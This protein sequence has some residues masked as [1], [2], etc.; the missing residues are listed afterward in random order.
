MTRPLLALFL[1]I[2]Y[3]SQVFAESRLIFDSEF[4]KVSQILLKYQVKDDYIKM[5]DI[6]LTNTNFG[7]R[8]EDPK[9]LTAYWPSEVFVSGKFELVLN[10]GDILH[11]ASITP[12]AVQT[13]I[14]NSG[15]EYKNSYPNHRI[16]ISMQNDWMEKVK[17]AGGLFFCLKNAKP[18]GG[19]EICSS[20]FKFIKNQIGLSSRNT[21]T[22]VLINGSKIAANFGEFALDPSGDSVVQWFA[23]LATGLSWSIQEKPPEIKIVE[24]VKVDENLYRL[25]G[26]GRRPL[27][28]FND[29]F[30]YMNHSFL[31]EY[32][33]DPFTHERED[34]WSVVISAIKPIDLSF[35]NPQGGIYTAR[36]NIAEAP[37]LLENPI[38]TNKINPQLTYSSATRYQLQLSPDSKPAASSIIEPDKIANSYLWQ[39]SDMPKGMVTTH[40]LTTMS[41]KKE[42]RYFLEN[43]RGYPFDLG[44]QYTTSSVAGVI[45]QGG[46]MHASFWIEDF[47][48]V[49]SSD[50]MRLRWGLQFKTFRP[51]NKI[52]V[53]VD[54][55]G[56][57][58]KKIEV[59][60]S[61]VDL[62]Y[63]FTPG[64]WG[65]DETTGAMLVQHDFTF[66][67][68]KLQLLGGG[69]FW[70]R[71]MPKAFDDLMN[72]I[73]LFKYPKWVNS[74]LIIFFENQDKD[75]K[76]KNS[77][78]LNFY[79]R[80][81]WTRTFYGDLGFG[82]RSY[83]FTDSNKNR[84]P[85]L[86]LFFLTF[87][88]GLLF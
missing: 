21:S 25:S 41:G 58:T 2:F 86:N 31:H 87:G 13:Y 51:Q 11:S 82:Y 34:Y 68:Y 38:I 5:G 50:W 72:H 30:S 29:H 9:T 4:S 40:T 65:R 17:Q 44:F 45:V 54:S 61:V 85:F 77:Y 37:A 42:R 28:Y 43:Y 1:V 67:E 52:T 6:Y 18:E 56:E 53:S 57:E 10:N 35:F 27:K 62:K 7:L 55:K 46:E 8:L 75:L 22:R 32:K 15:D 74:E 26:Y 14:L 81:N 88:L 66:D 24:V 69:V 33:P 80:L 48:G 23:Q 78:H 39:I 49:A 83:S 19:V 16:L 76:L 73:P 3:F 70:S 12:E 59:L 63:R 60:S 47:W 84:E 36:I 20:L 71:S 79:G 64:L